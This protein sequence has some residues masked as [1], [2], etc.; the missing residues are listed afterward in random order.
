VAAD[1]LLPM[2]T[3]LRREVKSPE[4]DLM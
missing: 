3:G 1:A 2:D 4:N